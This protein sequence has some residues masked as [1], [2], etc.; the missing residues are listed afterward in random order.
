LR[1]WTENII[2]EN[3]FVMK[4]VKG[5]GEVTVLQI[6]KR[7]RKGVWRKVIGNGG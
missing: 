5:K 2:R 7:H 4:V 1:K 3:S 6:E